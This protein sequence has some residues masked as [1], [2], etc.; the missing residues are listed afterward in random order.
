MPRYLIWLGSNGKNGG[1][2]PSFFLDSEWTGELDYLDFHRLLGVARI[3][4]VLKGSA[5]CG[6]LYIPR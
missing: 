5:G 2:G 3:T 4:M 6:R 1:G